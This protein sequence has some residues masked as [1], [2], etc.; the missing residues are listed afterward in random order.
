[1]SSCDTCLYQPGPSCT[2]PHITKY[3]KLVRWAGRRYTVNGWLIA[4]VGNSPTRY[5]QI[6]RAAWQKYMA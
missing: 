2:C 3:L 4:M 5:E 6:A 1:M